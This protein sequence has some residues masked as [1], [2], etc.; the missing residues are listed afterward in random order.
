MRHNE[1]L[2]GWSENVRKVKVSEVAALTGLSR[3]TIDR[4]LNG[5]S[6]VHP[7]TERLIQAAY[8]RLGLDSPSQDMPKIE[9]PD[10]PPQAEAVLRLGRGL[11][12]QLLDVVAQRRLPIDI[13][14]MYQEDADSI[15]DRVRALCA[16]S[17]RPIIVAAKNDQRLCEELVK[18]RRRG[19]RVIALVSDLDPSARDFFVGIDNR[20][21]GHAAAQLI[22]RTLGDGRAKVGVI[23]G[24][25][26]FRCHEDREIGFRSFLRSAYPEIILADVVKG[27][28]SRDQTRRAVSD[29]L[30]AH[31]DIRAIYNVA[32][33][34]LGVADALEE[35]D[36]QG[37]IFVVTHEAN[38]IT[39]PLLRS[40]IL[41]F[42][43]AQDP[44]DLI[45]ETVAA[46]SGPLG[47]SRSEVRLVDF[48]I[49]SRFNIPQFGLVARGV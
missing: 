49:Y 34:N 15:L 10:E 41:G 23:L 18:A 36:R 5:R 16:A 35:V 37:E 17:E 42:V 27:E 43:M 11:T 20:M 48:G 26:A 19:K 38:A 25:Y 9:R 32:G 46:M 7:R 24:D 29:L 4:A 28:D 40:G 3:A 12:E 22:G 1:A 33:G 6:G 14:D 8:E 47:G 44:A 31:P 2:P 21:A 39:V 30:S 13:H 45:R